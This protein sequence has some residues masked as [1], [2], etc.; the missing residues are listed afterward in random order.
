MNTYTGNLHYEQ[1]DLYVPAPGLPLE[2]T[3]SYNVLDDSNRRMGYNWSHG[4]DYHVDYF[5]VN[6][7]AIA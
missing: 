3:R 1:Q 5:D 7:A 6:G 2:W 4:Y